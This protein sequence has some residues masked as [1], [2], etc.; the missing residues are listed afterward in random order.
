MKP[1]EASALSRAL[2][3]GFSG[4]NSDPRPRC[5][6]GFAPNPRDHPLPPA[7][8]EGGVRDVVP[9]GPPRS[10]APGADARCRQAARASRPRSNIASGAIVPRRRRFALIEIA[11]R[12]GACAR[13]P[14]RAS[15]RSAASAR[16][17]P[18]S[19]ARARAGGGAAQ[20]RPGP[21]RRAPHHEAQIVAL[22][23]RHLA[24][25]RREARA[26]E[27]H[28][29]HDDRHGRVPGARA[30]WGPH[31]HLRRDRVCVLRRA[32][33]GQGERRRQDG[34]GDRGAA[35]LV[36]SPPPSAPSRALSRRRLSRA[37]RRARVGAAWPPPEPRG[38]PCA[39]TGAPAHGA[40]PSPPRR[41]RTRRRRGRRRRRRRRRRV[42]ERSPS[43]EPPYWKST[44]LR[45]KALGYG[46]TP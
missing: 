45:R 41:A 1:E 11:P 42:P 8:T 5:P 18:P 13:A 7:R 46:D 37:G 35:H 16:R 33:G 43:R 19:A 25:L 36:G 29:T 17:R 27:P 9:K 40:V 30:A 6:R 4:Q 12:R 44:V 20:V 2:D 34:R 15:S 26:H 21:P 38:G 39:R 31:A 10:R 24:E 22:R 23:G 3:A 32:R 14:L 28:P